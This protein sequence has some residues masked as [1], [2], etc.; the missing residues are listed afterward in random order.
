MKKWSTQSRENA[1]WYQ[2]EE[3]GYNYRMSNIIA[4]MIRGQISHL[5]EHI[6]QKKAIWERYR[7]GLK[8]YPV[9]MNPI[10]LKK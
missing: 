6:E 1:E 5:E 3:L 8:E 9:S 2:H 10:D 7:D 4:G